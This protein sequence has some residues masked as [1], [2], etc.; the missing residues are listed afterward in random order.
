MNSTRFLPLTQ[1]AGNT[2]HLHGYA[3]TQLLNGCGCTLMSHNTGEVAVQ[4]NLGRNSLHNKSSLLKPGL[5]QQKKTR[6]ER[7]AREHPPEWFLME[8]AAVFFYRIPDLKQSIS[9]SRKWLGKLGKE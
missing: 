3:N 4:Y 1:D 8:P 9:V 7:K 6:M 5:V 2:L